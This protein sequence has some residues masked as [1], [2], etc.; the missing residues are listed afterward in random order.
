MHEEHFGSLVNYNYAAVAI[1][2]GPDMSFG[3]S[4][5]RLGIDGI[6]DTREGW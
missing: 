6:T 4:V 3:V 1:P 5:I 2:Y